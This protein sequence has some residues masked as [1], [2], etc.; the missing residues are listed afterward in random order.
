EPGDWREPR[1]STHGSEAPDGAACQS[2]GVARLPVLS[3]VRQG[4]PT[5]SSGVRLPAWP[6][7]RW[8]AGGGRPD[9]RGYRSVRPR[10]LAGRTDDR[11]ERANVSTEPR[12]TGF[13]PEIGWQTTPA[14]DRNDP[15]PRGANGRD[16][17]L[18]ADLRG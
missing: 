17:G 15:G 4:A 13:H 5:R 11:T 18:G 6:L 2:E 10:P 8:R 12:A 7:Q 16:A 9:L 3:T 14:R 1:T